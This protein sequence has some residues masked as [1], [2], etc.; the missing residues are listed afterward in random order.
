MEQE[1]IFNDLGKRSYKEVW[2]QQE[3]LL[4][5]NADIKMAFKFGNQQ[6]NAPEIIPTLHHLLFV[7]HFPVYTLGKNGKEEHVLISET[8]RL[9]KGIE[10]FHI[11]RGGDITF[12][13][14]GQLVGYPI[15]DLERFKTDLGWYLRSLE[16][17]IIKTMADYGLKGERSAGET[18]VWLDAHIKGKERKICAMGIKCSRWITMHGFAFNVNTDL[19]YF[20]HIVPCGIQNKK[21]TSLAQELGRMIDFEEVKYRVKKHF[22]AIFLCKLIGHPA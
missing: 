7:E 14:P 16:E 6:F 19:T 3:A 2:D 21:V 17:V 4:K 10:Y 5:A 15:L 13:G 12:H 18:G 20:D 22:E 8:D 1:V 9:K 11:N